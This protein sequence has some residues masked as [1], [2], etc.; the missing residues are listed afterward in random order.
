M[1]IL[2]IILGIIFAAIAIAVSYVY[3]KGGNV[4]D[5]EP[6]TVKSKIAGLILIAF[7]LYDVIQEI[8]Y[9]LQTYAEGWMT[10]NVEETV[11]IALSQ[12]ISLMLCFICLMIGIFL[13]FNKYAGVYGATI[14]TIIAT[15]FKAIFTTTIGLSYAYFSLLPLIVVL[16]SLVFIFSAIENNSRHFS[17]YKNLIR[18]SP[19]LLLLNLISPIATI[20]E[21]QTITT[22]IIIGI[23]SPI[24]QSI[25][26]FLTFSILIPNTETPENFVVQTHFSRNEIIILLLSIALAPFLIYFVSSFSK[27]WLLVG[28][29]LLAIAIPVVLNVLDDSD[30]VIKAIAVAIVI[31]IVLGI[32]AI[33]KALNNG[34][35]RM[36]SCGHQSC[37]EY[38]PFPCYG[39]NNTCSNKT[40]CYLD[41]YCSSCDR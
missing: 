24:L 6:S 35:S 25:A 9:L 26:F 16:V 7:S 12:S 20:I 33:S 30:I 23:I 19:F 2:L 18:F 28:G 13:F 5:L 31:V 29:V 14:A 37:A 15:L 1:A 27:I 17:R 32:C 34:S 40:D 22:P 41:L 21:F 36:P 39:K 4:Q 38:G 10:S 3:A 8:S 11:G